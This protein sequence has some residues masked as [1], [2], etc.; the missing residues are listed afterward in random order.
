MLPE[1]KESAPAVAS[2]F[3]LAGELVLGEAASFLSAGVGGVGVL[4]AAC[5]GWVFGLGVEA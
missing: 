4:S 5:W 3:G 2:G 1:P